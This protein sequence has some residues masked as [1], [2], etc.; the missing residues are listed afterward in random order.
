MFFRGRQRE[1]S[2]WRRFRTSPDGF[3]FVQE[4]ELWTAH[5]VA[6]AERVVEALL[7]L[8]DVDDVGQVLR[9]LAPAPTSS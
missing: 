9:L 2:V 4:G 5:V 3:T 1:A 7:S 8:E 6:N